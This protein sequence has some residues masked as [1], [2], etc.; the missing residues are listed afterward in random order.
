M[1]LLSAIYRTTKERLT[2]TASST[3]PAAV[4]FLVVP[5][6]SAVQLTPL[7][8]VLTATIVGGTVPA[9]VTITSSLGGTTTGPLT[10]L[11]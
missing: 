9:S 5:G 1:T 6:S 10:R 7:N 4:L 2:V 11:R 8:G 3:D